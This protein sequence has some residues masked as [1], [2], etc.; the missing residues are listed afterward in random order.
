MLVLGAVGGSNEAQSN[1]V[2]YVER[3][4]EG[5]FYVGLNYSPAFSKITGFEIR[6]S[7]GETAAVYPYNKDGRRV[8]WKANNFDWNTPDPR[9]KFKDNPIVALEGSV[10]Y[11]IGSARVELEI[12]YEQFKTKGIRDTGTK[13]EEA[14]TVYLL[15][16][17]LPHTLVSGENEKFKELLKETKAE[18]IVKF[19]EAVGQQAKDIDGKVC[20]KKKVNGPTSNGN[21]EADASGDGGRWSCIDY[22][23]TGTGTNGYNNIPHATK[24]FAWRFGDLT[25]NVPQEDKTGA[26]AT[27]LNGTTN[28]GWPGTSATNTKT[29]DAVA[30]ELSG[31]NVRERNTVAGLLSKTVSG[32]EVVEIRAVS[33]TSVMLNACYDLQSEGFSV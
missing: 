16:K 31:L 22:S 3:F 1:D 8:E 6:E 11:S 27:D 30:G 4:G 12:G 2:G 33:T 14:D 29:A 32:A 7:T 5:N 28:R 21:P 17:K 9:I 23:G 15:A 19:A 13:E 20:A 18:E 26:T 10:G 24:G 25:K